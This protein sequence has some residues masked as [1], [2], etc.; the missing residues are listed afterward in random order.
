MVFGGAQGLEGSIAAHPGA[1]L[2]APS[3]PTSCPS[4]ALALLS[5]GPLPTL[6]VPTHLVPT[7]PRT[8]PCWALPGL[9]AAL[10]VQPGGSGPCLSPVLCPPRVADE[11]SPPNKQVKPLF[12]H[13]RRID[14]CLQ[15]RVAFRGSDE[16]EWL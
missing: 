9:P 8:R 1:L 14:S 10:G 12:R 13:F 4:H 16:S 11:T 15:T 7:L 3:R 2:V 6:P 5:L